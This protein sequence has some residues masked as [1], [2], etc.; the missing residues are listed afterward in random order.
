MVIERY[1]RWLVVKERKEYFGHL[2]NSHID[3]LMQLSPSLLPV[4]RANHFTIL[5]ELES[6]QGRLTEA[7]VKLAQG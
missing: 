3:A 7:V 4:A 5:D 2:P 6:P 1:V